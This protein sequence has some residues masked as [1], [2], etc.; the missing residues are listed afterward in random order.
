MEIGTNSGILA[1]F[2]TLQIGPPPTSLQITTLQIWPPNFGGS[3]L[4]CIDAY[5]SES[6]LIFQHFSRSTQI[7]SW[8]F[9]ILRILTLFC[10][11]FRKFPDFLQF[12]CKKLVSARSRL[13]RRQ[14]F[15]ENAH[16][17]AF[18]EIYTI[19]LL[20]FPNFAKFLPKLKTG[21]G[22]SNL[23][24]GNLKTGEG[25]FRKYP[26]ICAYLEGMQKFEA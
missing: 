18:S 19:I 15:R 22:G 2:A 12:C 7:S 8:I 17:S 24:S 5:D 3:Y 9:K 20:N 10:R 4:G 1:E 21:R 6:R 25:G 14:F 23:K 16:F 11:I 13:Y 26:R